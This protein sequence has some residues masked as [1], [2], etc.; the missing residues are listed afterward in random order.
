MTTLWAPQYGETANFDS[1]PGDSFIE[2][3]K[4]KFG[5][6]VAIA[7]VDTLRSTVFGDNITDFHSSSILE[8][9]LRTAQTTEFSRKTIALNS[10]GSRQGAQQCKEISKEKKHSYCKWKI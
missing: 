10:V 5:V 2:V 4:G 9:W 6:C 8:N 1:D 7:A 3:N